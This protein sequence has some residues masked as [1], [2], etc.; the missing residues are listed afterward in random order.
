VEAVVEAEEIPR[1][2][3]EPAARAADMAPEEEEEEVPQPGRTAGPAELA[4]TEWSW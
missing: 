4:R 1:E 2:P 3:G